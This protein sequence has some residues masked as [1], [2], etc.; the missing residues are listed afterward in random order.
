[1]LTDPDDVRLQGK[2]GSHRR[3][4]K[5]TR[6]TQH[7][8]RRLLCRVADAASSR[9]IGFRIWWS[10]SPSAAVPLKGAAN[11]WMSRRAFG[12]AI[13]ASRRNNSALHRPWR[14]SGTV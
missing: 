8:H 3:R 12:Q 4:A 9:Q 13:I 1:M 5:P 2:T 6:L 14:H 7:G 10:A 11:T